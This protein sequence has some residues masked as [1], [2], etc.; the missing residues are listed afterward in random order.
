MTT[1]HYRGGRVFSPGSTWAESVVVQD[2]RIVFVGDADVAD[3]RFERAEVVDLHGR[4][5]MPGFID[6]HTHIVGFGESL[7]QI[8]LLDAG[9]LAEIARRI[10]AFAGADPAAPRIVGHGWLYTAIDGG[11]PTRALLDAVE[12]DRPVYLTAND[13]HSSWL[14]SAAL[15][16]LGIDSSTPDPI[17]GQIGRDAA[18]EP[19]G[20]LYEAASLQLMRTFLD[21]QVTDQ[22]RDDALRLALHRYRADGVTTVVDMAT[23]DDDLGALERALAA[24]DGRLPVRV[25]MHWLV[26]QRAT[27]AE[28][29]AQVARAVELRARLDSPWLSVRGIKLMVDGVIDSCTA[30]MSHPFADGSHPD[31]LWDRDALTAVV[32]AADA[33]GLQIA[34]HAIGDAA[35]DLALDALEQAAIRNGPRA[36]R[37]HRL[38]HLEYVAPHNVERLAALGVVA[39]MQPVHS[40]PAI[41]ENWAA[42]LGDHRVERGFAWPEFTDAGAVVAFGTDAPTAPNAPLPNMF[43]ATTRRSAI[44]PTLPPNNPRYALSMAE[45]FA[46]GTSDAAYA[47]QMESFTGRLTAGY[48]ADFIVLDTDSFVRGPDSLLVARPVIHVV[49]GRRTSLPG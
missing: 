45:A 11:R 21:A 41:G 38:E 7:A 28:N 9:D 43:I 24:G 15:R 30:A 4:L 49:G 37:R 20:M 42:V 1:V 6:A 44:D 13:Q 46:H 36:T 19:D 47:S 27:D 33:A 18:G 10:T 34:M 5:T 2:D 8:D 3:Q 12:P 22:Q 23:T 25:A 39:S 40:D 17:G 14:N 48:A 35:S 31:P 16:E 29:L 26:E 32:V